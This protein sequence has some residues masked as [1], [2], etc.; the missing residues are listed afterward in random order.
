MLVLEASLFQQKLLKTYKLSFYAI[1]ITLLQAVCQTCISGKKTR[2]RAQDGRL[3][4]LIFICLIWS[5]WLHFFLS[6]EGWSTLASQRQYWTQPC[7]KLYI[8]L[9]PLFHEPSSWRQALVCYTLLC[10]SIWIQ[11]YTTT[12]LVARANSSGKVGEKIEYIWE[13][14]S[15]INLCSD[16]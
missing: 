3:F 14:S 2:K 12:R 15:N 7:L 5:Y 4:S 10:G 9:P 11:C 13:K 6:K 8:L 16:N 1:D